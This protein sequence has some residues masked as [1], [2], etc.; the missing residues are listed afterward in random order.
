MET[1]KNKP[2]SLE[3]LPFGV[4]GMFRTENQNWKIANIDHFL[5]SRWEN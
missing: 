5:K 2:F 1:F 3:N 4:K